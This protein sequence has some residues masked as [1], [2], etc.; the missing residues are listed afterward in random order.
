MAERVEHCG[1]HFLTREIVAILAGA[2][3]GQDDAVVA[4]SLRRIGEHFDVDRVIIAPVA[5]TGEIGAPIGVWVSNDW[6]V[7]G[8]G[9]SVALPPMPRSAEHLIRNGALVFG[10]LDD[11]P[12]PEEREAL[13]R[14]GIGAS[15]VAILGNAGSYLIAIAL[16]S[17]RTEIDWPE[18]TVHD[19]QV[20][21]AL[22]LSTLHHAEIEK[23]VEKLRG[24]SKLTS[25]ISA[26]FVNL[27]A[28]RV[29][30]EVENALGRVSEH[31]DVDLAT[32][33]Q[34]TDS[35]RTSWMVSHEWASDA[36]GGPHFRGTVIAVEFPWLSA[37]LKDASPLFIS[38]LDDLPPEAAVERA[39][40]ER[41]GIQSMLVV[42]Y[43]TESSI[44]GHVFL[45]TVH[46]QRSWSDRVVPQLRLVGQV[47][48]GAVEKQRADVA[49]GR[50]HLE[51]RTLKDRLEAE[52]L[53]LREEVR[54]SFEHEDLI[55]RSPVLQGIRH[56]AEQV[57]VT[58]SAVLLLGETG[59][60]KGL[61]ARAIHAD[62][63]R[64]G[65][66][67]ITVNCAALPALLIESE[68]FGHE[69]GA[70]T[71]AVARKI[72]RFEMAAGGTLFLDEIGDLP[73][74]LQ[75]KLLRVL[76]DREFERLGSSET[77]TTDARVIAATNRNLD[78]LVD[79]GAF[80]ADLYYRLHVFPIRM[81][82]L[83]EHREDIPL[84]V[85]YFLGKL[86]GRLGRQVETVSPSVMEKLKAYA[87]PGNVRELQNVLE[88]AV[89]LSPGSTLELG[90]IPLTEDA[91]ERLPMAVRQTGV[92]TLQDV[93]RNH[94]LQV[95]EDCGWKVRGKAGAADRLGLKRTTLNSRMKKLGIRRP[96]AP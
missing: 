76:H 21:G 66:P 43:E 38:S 47:L 12:G 17:F 23:E 96:P 11:L 9:L 77:M 54:Q 80:R 16:D 92:K 4:D 8:L 5:R 71:G 52:N 68:L 63:R 36:A 48:A 41:I 18:G 69:K 57:A 42:P 62:S 60:G 30:N 86:R 39:S 91:G 1:A 7:R 46:R 74:E 22:I 19:L 56:Q 53:S 89:I 65:R 59:T 64:A 95:L 87:W 35:S 55:G 32:L 2:A 94:I 10:T 58:N 40:C 15:A 26:R 67:L 45:N 50:A 6:R 72:G 78:M 93:E 79:K 31:L 14:L 13:R 33:T 24:F 34:W 75:A 90:N 3:P 25:E 29:D 83:R 51:I 49:L 85:W 37:R 70:F 20:L 88:R 44:G 61:I 73:L 84:L 28:E 82:P 27:P 81:P